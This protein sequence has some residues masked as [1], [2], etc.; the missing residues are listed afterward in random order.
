MY[1]LQ[2]EAM[3]QTNEVVKTYRAK[4][5]LSLRDF[6]DELNRELV[7]T[8]VTYATVSRW[9]NGNNYYEPDL[10]LLFECMAT[11]RDW[12]ATWAADCLASMFP[13][14][15]QSGIVRVKLPRAE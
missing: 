14:L 3:L 5:N 10:R 6:A 15:F 7:N 8:G 1:K 12:R 13:D 2:G 9:E 4:Q 11:Y